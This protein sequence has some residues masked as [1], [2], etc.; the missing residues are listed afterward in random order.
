MPI[1][2]IH[3]NAMPI[4]VIK[5]TVK[6]RTALLKTCEVI[7]LHILFSAHKHMFEEYY[8]IKKFSC[9]MIS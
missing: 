9:L 5:V 6:T 4:A 8:R 7:I 1:F 3:R 2:T